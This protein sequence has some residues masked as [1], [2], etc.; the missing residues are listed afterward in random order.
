MPSDGSIMREATP[1]SLGAILLILV[2]LGYASVLILAPLF[3]IVQGAFARGLEP[4]IQ[5]FST[6]DVQHALQVTFT[7]ALGAVA[8]NAVAGL[9]TAWVLVRHRFRG[10]KLFDTLVDI[11]FVFSPVIAGYA[12]IVLFGRNGWLAPPII[13]IVFAL[14]GVL[15]AKTFVSLPFVTRELQPV[16]E[17]MTPEQ[18]EAAYTIGASRWT[19]FWQVILPE[20]WTALLYGIVLTF[21]RA[22]GEFGAVAVV[23]GSIEGLTETATSFVFRG[24]NDRNNIGAFSVSLLLGLISISVLFILNRLKRRVLRQG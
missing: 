13:P 10:K 14:P 19:T 9:I 17:A 15:L 16:L 8:I 1:R 2:V 21:A 6:P 22:V 23:G 5:T 18:E 7:L 20:L 4:I 3:A 12:L 11:P 24:M